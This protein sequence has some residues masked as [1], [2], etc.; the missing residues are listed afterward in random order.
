M[1]S[2]IISSYQPH[3][4]NKLVK[5]ISETIG[6]DFIYEII[7]VWNPNLMSITE[8]YNAGAEKSNYNNL[9]FLHEDLIFHT[10]GWG[11]VLTDHLSVKQTG[12]IGVA[13]SAYVPYAPSSWAISKEYNCINIL[14]GNKN[15]DQYIHNY[16]LKKKRNPVF[17]VDGVFLAILKKNYNMFKF[18]SDLRG[19][20]GYDL[21]FSLR[22]SQKFQNF[23]VD[24]ILIQH[25]SKGNQDKNWL[26]TNIKI[27]E[28]LNVKLDQIINCETEKD[29]FKGFLYQYFKFYPIN[30]NNLLFC[31]KFYPFKR[32][33]FAQHL[34][35]L[36]FFF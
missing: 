26:D 27:R 21:D 31:L 17:A 4:Y 18:D 33:K 1:L 34:L 15:N 24:D 7:Q 3:Y 9:L 36:K 5:N 22:V 23:V 19:F 20:H 6:N 14:Q 16:E 12:I 25:F 10:K 28:K 32:I 30:L 2:I 11:K 29:A 8:A 13:G 35:F